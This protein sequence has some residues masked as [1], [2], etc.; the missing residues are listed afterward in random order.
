MGKIVMGLDLIGSILADTGTVHIHGSPTDT[1]TIHIHGS[2][3][4]IRNVRVRRSMQ[5]E[6][7][8]PQKS[9]G[10]VMPPWIL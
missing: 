5:T 10:P 2:P 8:T 1:G 6:V 4:D 3:V 9:D 7:R